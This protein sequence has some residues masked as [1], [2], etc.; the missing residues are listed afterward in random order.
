M[1]LTMPLIHRVSEK[2]YGLSQADGRQVV[3]FNV[4]M[5]ATKLSITEAVQSQFD[6][7]VSEVRTLVSKGRKIRTIRLGKS[8]TRPGFGHRSDTKKAYVT[9]VAGS[10]IA[11][12]DEPKEK[13]EAK[14]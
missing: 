10:R 13:K 5:D 6:V 14:K 4:P 3:V 8:H 11:V 12:F 7:K 9:L 1:S 2:A